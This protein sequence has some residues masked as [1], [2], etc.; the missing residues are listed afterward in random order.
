MEKFQELRDSANKKLK[1]ADYIL[2]MTYPMVKDPK[3][4]LAA[5][6]N[7]FL[8][9]SYSMS[10]LLYY[11]QI[12]KRIPIF[13]DNF[14]SK[15]E[16]F[17]NKCLERYKIDADYIK[18]IKELKEIIILHKKSPLEFPR[19]ESLI[20]C[21]DSYRMRTVSPV[22]VKEYVEKAKLFI[23]RVSTIVSKDESIFR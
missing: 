8:A 17:R 3:L 10:S 22:M 9:Y 6:E 11:E 7:L 18:I 20:I 15:L 12:F 14:S 5:T 21:N 4:L 1:I 2:T 23:K 19:N 13:P 16:V